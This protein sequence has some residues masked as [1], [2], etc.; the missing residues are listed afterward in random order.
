ME[1]KP[2]KEV[3]EAE[4][5]R[6]VME[7]G[8]GVAAFFDLDGTLIPLPSLEERFF[9]RLNEERLIGIRNRLCWLAEAV[10]LA[11]QGI[12]Q[13]VNANKMYL[14]GVRTEEASGGARLLVCRSAEDEEAKAGKRTKEPERQAKMSVLTFFPTAI[15]R[16]AWHAKRGHLNVIVSGTLEPLAA[17][18][19][20]TMEAEL[21]ARGLTCNIRV[22]ATRLGEEKERWTGRIVGEAMFGEAKA[23]AIRRIAAE[24][25]LDLERCFAYGDS[26]SDR[27]MLE[28]VGKPAAVNPSNDLGRL[29]RRNCWAILRWGGEKSFTQRTRR[30]TRSQRTEETGRGLQAERVNSEHGA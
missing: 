1:E 8:G 10:R 29:A 17:L 12:G 5:V 24:S 26:L 18:V 7:K 21:G 6:E 16:A 25:D 13:I 23:R 3:K 9:L 19:A 20:R 11:P 28:T 14:R 4:D 2:V 30:G 22:C 27:W 15:E